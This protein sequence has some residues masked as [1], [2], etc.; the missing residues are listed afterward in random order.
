VFQYSHYEIDCNYMLLMDNL[1]DLTHLGYV[2]LKTIGGMPTVHV[3]ATQET[4]KTEHGVHLLRWMLD[5]PAPPTFARAMPFKGNVDRWSDFEYIAPMTVLQF[6]GAM[7]IGRKA[8]ENRNQEGAFRARLYH[9]ATP[10]TETS[11]YYFFSVGRGFAQN[12]TKIGQQFF[13]EV[14]VTFL[15]DKKIIEAQQRNLSREPDRPLLVRQH[16]EAVALARRAME[17][18]AKEDHKIAAAAE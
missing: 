10:R 16:D 13:D 15:E 8:Q 14:G 11:C 3:E 4:T 17:R 7:D 12:D 6:G 9:G 1:M 18:L 2:H 5:A